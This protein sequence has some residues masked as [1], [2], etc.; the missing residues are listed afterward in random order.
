MEDLRAAGFECGDRVQGLTREQARSAV[1]WLAHFHVASHHFIERYGNARFR[2]DFPSMNQD[3][4]AMEKI[5]PLVAFFTGMIRSS[6][7][8]FKAIVKEH[9]T[10]FFLKK[11]SFWSALTKC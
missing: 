10:V 4:L 5:N 3:L 8:A 7:K 1:A 11:L 9:A 6:D 2:K